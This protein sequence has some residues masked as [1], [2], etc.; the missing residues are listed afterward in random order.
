MT[1]IAEEIS[2]IKSRSCV[3]FFLVDNNL[4]NVLKCLRVHKISLNSLLC[5]YRSAPS[6][7]SCDILGG[8]LMLSDLSFLLKVRV[9]LLWGFHKL[10]IKHLKPYQNIINTGHGNY[11]HKLSKNN[12]SQEISSY[13]EILVKPE[14]KQYISILFAICH[15]IWHRY[16]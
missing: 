4:F 7:T 3:L 11:I 14:F 1:L 15:G 5:S 13:T 8:L 2:R 6:L 12:W 10:P 9:G 16:C